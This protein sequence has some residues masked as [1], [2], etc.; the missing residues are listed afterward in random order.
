MIKP[1]QVCVIVS[2]ITFEI[3]FTVTDIAA[4]G[5]RKEEVVKVLFLTEIC[6]CEPP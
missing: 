6:E 2:G 1:E 3:L 5:V 4:A